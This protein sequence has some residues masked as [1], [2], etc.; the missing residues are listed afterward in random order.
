VITEVPQTV[1]LST[2][3]Q[4]IISIALSSLSLIVIKR[5]VSVSVVLLKWLLL[6]TL[7]NY[8][9]SNHQHFSFNFLFKFTHNK[10]KRGKGER[11]VE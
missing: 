1:R 2:R 10:I 6:P 7:P 9:P 11:A 3:L 4:D 5:L 8:V